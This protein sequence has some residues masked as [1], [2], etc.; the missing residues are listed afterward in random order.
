MSEISIV[1]CG[2]VGLLTGTILAHKNKDKSFI[3][4]DVDKN[5]IDN[6]KNGI[7][8]IKE[9]EFIDYYND[10]TNI[11]LSSDFEDIKNSDII[12]I[13]VGTPD[14]D[15]K[16]DLSYLYSTIGEIN[17]FSKNEAIIIIKSTVE[18]GTTYKLM[19]EEFR[20]DL[21]I[22]N[23]PEFLAEGEAINNLLNPC[24]L[25]IGWTK[26]EDI[27]EA[28]KIKTLYNHIDESKIY[29]TDSN[30][31]ELSKL[32][33][34]FML[35]QRVA[36]INAIEYLAHEK[37]ANIKDI[38]NILKMDDRIG[39]KYLSPSAGFGGSCFRKDINNISNICSD[40]IFRNYFESINRINDYHM[41]HLA[42]RIDRFKYVLFLGYGFKE[43]TN[44][45]RESP[46]EF[47]SK[48][49]CKPCRYDIYDIHIDKYNNKPT[50]LNKYECVILMLNEPE[51]IEIA[52]QLPRDKI[53]DT[54]YI[55]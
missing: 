46:T 10:L 36:S 31:S 13:A 42:N 55:L 22:F 19:K 21:H 39:N 25:L 24:R 34:N 52:K 38:S 9:P 4:I 17:K 49:L 45:T 7:H 41:V 2:Y 1:G 27:K 3:F 26:E 30:T 32:A 5:K 11:K 29:I 18:V 37:N 35:S 14:K 40:R 23:I 6:L 54:K 51:Y 33:S 16:C 47:I 15:G 28:E 50:D 44:D 8:F 53:I 48:M 12:F 43:Y 20:K